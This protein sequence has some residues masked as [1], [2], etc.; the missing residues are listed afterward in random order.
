MAIPYNEFLAQASSGDYRYGLGT[1][2]VIQGQADLEPGDYGQQ[3]VMTT[4]PNTT[5]MSK[6]VGVAPVARRQNITRMISELEFLAGTP[7]IHER[8]L[9]QK[10]WQARKAL[11]GT[12]K[13]SWA[14]YQNPRSSYDSYDD[15]VSRLDAV[16]AVLGTRGVSAK[17]MSQLYGMGGLGSGTGWTGA[18]KG[19]PWGA[20]GDPIAKL[21][22]CIRGMICQ[23]KGFCCPPGRQFEDPIYD[24]FPEFEEFE[25]FPSAAGGNGT[26][27]PPPPPPPPPPPKEEPPPY[28]QP[29]PVTEKSPLIAYREY[30]Q[31]PKKKGPVTGG[32]V[33]Y[34]QPKP[35]VK[36]GGGYTPVSV[37]SKPLVGGA[38]VARTPGV[39]VG[40]AGRAVTGVTRGLVRG[41]GGGG[42]GG[43]MIAMAG[44]GARR[45]SPALNTLVAQIRA[46]RMQVRRTR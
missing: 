37:A 35:L 41:S 34:G 33:T 11:M 25:E 7:G 27:S 32:G 13:W 38:G 14:N 9:A 8:V 2:T 21:A 16:E 30:T 4:K 29:P 43:G 10:V 3:Y 39:L 15:L 5:V 31:P 17:I 26:W 44:L 20:G 22:S 19:A 28:W 6:R 23:P 46:A 45:Q 24:D 36:V 40:G 1:T 42:G 12:S 18:Y